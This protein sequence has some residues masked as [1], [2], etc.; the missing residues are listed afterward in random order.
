MRSRH[1]NEHRARPGIAALLTALCGMQRSAVGR[2][3]PGAALARGQRSGA[4][5]VPSRRLPPRLSHCPLSG[6]APPAHGQEDALAACHAG[7]GRPTGKN[8]PNYDSVQHLK[9]GASRAFPA[10]KDGQLCRNSREA[11]SAGRHA[12]VRRTRRVNML[13]QTACSTS[14]QPLGEQFKLPKP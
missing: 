13:N 7:A 14:C 1:C 9:S 5:V 4:P 10:L 8:T 3:V 2:A 12:G 6:A 11:S